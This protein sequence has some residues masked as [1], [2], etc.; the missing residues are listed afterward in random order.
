MIIDKINLRSNLPNRLPF[1]F[2]DQDN[3]C[4]D[5]VDAVKTF[6]DVVALAKEMI[7]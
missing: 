1:D 3:E 5:K 4:L 2:N 7:D 6:D